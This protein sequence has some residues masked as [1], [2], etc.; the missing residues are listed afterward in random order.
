MTPPGSPGQARSLD[1]RRIPAILG[2]PNRSCVQVFGVGGS[3]MTL[4][5]TVADL[6]P[7][8]ANR[9]GDRAAILY[10]SHTGR[11]A[12]IS[13]KELLRTAEELAA[14]LVALGLSA[15]DRV[16]ILCRT[17][18]EW[19]AV[20]RAV[21]MAGG[22]VV[23]VY[24]TNSPEECEW[25]LG[26]SGAVIAFCE[27]AD[28]VAK[29]ASIR[30]R[31]PRLRVVATID[32][33]AGY[34]D[35]GAVRAAGHDGD[36]REVIRRRSALTPL[37]IYTVVY[38]SGTTGPPKGTVLTHG[39]YRA[40]IE[41][42]ADRDVLRGADD[43]AFLFLPLA[44]SFALLIQNAA[45]RCGTTVA[46]ASGDTQALMSEIAECRPTFLPSVPRLF[47]KVHR[48]IIAGIDA[49][50]LAQAVNVGVRAHNLLTRG[51]AVPNDLYEEYLRRTGPLAAR[52]RSAFGGR[53]RQASSG[54][55][56]I[57][58]DVLRFFWSCGIPVMEGYGLTETAT[59]VTASTPEHHR[60]GSV[61]RAVPDVRLVIA[62][63]GEVLISAPSLMSG[64]WR[65]PVATATAIVDGWLH[66][67][68]I[69]RLDE[70]GYLF[71]TGRKKDIIITSGGKNL[72]PANL[73]N[74][75]RTCP[76]VSHAVMHGDGR[77][78]PVM[79]VTLDAAEAGRWAA[80]RGLGNLPLA[81]LAGRPELVA[82]IQAVLD[83]ANRRYAR[84]EQVKK[85]IILDHDLTVAGGELTA[86][87]KVRRR[88]V[89]ERY[90]DLF[91]RLYADDPV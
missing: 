62:D 67:G 33:V 64:Y 38:T 66:T 21:T 76:L 49:D 90:A 58:P 71:I 73:E 77:P 87:Q 60:F 91:D 48:Q 74:D 2:L 35:L 30:D 41:S 40:G 11:W 22:A 15:G 6:L 47:E 68:D 25:V 19:T 80:R 50:D 12:A 42:V 16:A 27:D 54:G 14:G 89:N 82:T 34:P 75:V 72:T 53:L 13:F 51:E 37:D 85:F 56:P 8:A 20:D 1:R 81:T 61:G 65:N 44:H 10:R 9:Y 84:V 23:P 3:A 46:Y 55:A 70:D 29:V 69:G 7:Q 78:Y 31:L 83:A 45:C 86:T 57:D 26:D 43:T 18:P 59:A 52:V 79:L 88:V 36:L 4:S 24:P 32:P 5:G 28:Q 39:A 63:D 17:R